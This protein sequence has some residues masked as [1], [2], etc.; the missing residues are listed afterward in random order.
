MQ[1]EVSA[2]HAYPLGDLAHV[3][4]RHAQVTIECADGGQIGT[5]DLWCLARFARQ[6]PLDSVGQIR[7]VHLLG[8]QTMPWILVIAF[9]T[10]S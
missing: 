4:Q 3:I 10:G 9:D 1:D 6:M 2:H 7:K 8:L 5:G